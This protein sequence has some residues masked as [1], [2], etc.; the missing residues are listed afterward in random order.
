MTLQNGLVHGG[1]AYLW[2][3]TGFFDSTTGELVCLD[4]KV[5]QGLYW[6]FAGALSCIGGNPHEIA[7]H[8][9]NAWPGDVPSLLA[10]TT[11]ALRHYAAKGFIARVLLATWADRPQLWMI[12]TDDCAGEGAFVPCEVLHY[13]NSANGLPEVQRAERMGFTPKRMARVIDAQLANSVEA[14]GPMGAAGL[15]VQYGGNVVQYEVSRDGLE[16]RVLRAV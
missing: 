10:T 9:S 3:D 4:T 13:M 12:G 8:I 2:A 5:F 15:K 14:A 11:D 16:S 7:L 1:K 6:P